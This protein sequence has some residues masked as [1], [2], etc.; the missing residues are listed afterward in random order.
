MLQLLGQRAWSTNAV[1]GDAAV[2]GATCLELKVDREA[3]MQSK[4]MEGIW[5]LAARV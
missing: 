1:R 5:A 4:A 3:P 2:V